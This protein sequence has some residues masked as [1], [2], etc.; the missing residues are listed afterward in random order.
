MMLAIRLA[1]ALLFLSLCAQGLPL[2]TLPLN[3]RQQE[4][5]WQAWLLVDDQNQHRQNNEEGG[6]VPRRRITTK[7]VFVAPTLA[8]PFPDNLP[9]C[10]EGYESNPMGVCTKI[11]KIDEDRHLAFLVSKLNEKFGIEDYEED[12]E[13]VDGSDSEPL[14]VN[15]PL[16]DQYNNDTPQGVE[17][18]FAIIVT[19]TIKNSEGVSNV[20]KREGETIGEPIE[21]EL[22]Q[23]L[24]TTTEQYDS[25]TWRPEIERGD[26]TT[27]QSPVEETTAIREETTR[28][29]GEVETTTVPDE[30]STTTVLPESTYETTEIPTTTLETTTA[31]EQYRVTRPT[32]RITTYHPK[33][34]TYHPYFDVKYFESNSKTR[35]IIK[36]PDDDDD[37][38]MPRSHSQGNYVRF[39]D[40]ESN[41]QQESE[42]H[43]TRDVTDSLGNYFNE[44]VTPEP[45][46]KVRQ[47]VLPGK[48]GFVPSK[49]Y[50]VVFPHH[51]DEENHRQYEYHW[52]ATTESHH[53]KRIRDKQGNLF[54]LP[55]KWSEKSNQKP[56]VFRS[57]PMQDLSV[58]FGYKNE[59]TVHR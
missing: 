14:Q 56:L 40:M 35:N 26:L 44:I 2:P 3:E 50:P 20:D 49:N 4:I 28:F 45:S 39:P 21:Q 46:Q 55:P 12:F 34:T 29:D 51:N 53:S 18:D 22:K 15:I 47:M 13:E 38:V 19:P 31:T 8:G 57:L 17:S 52:G 25:T 43:H 41:Y 10:A 37:V 6:T 30:G 16:A 59:Q 48:R 23:L 42:N 27:T 1:Y 11:I 36:F 24:K 33:A 7:S 9:P 54:L 32:P 5:S 58:L